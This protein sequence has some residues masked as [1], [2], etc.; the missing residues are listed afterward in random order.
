MGLFGSGMSR[1]FVIFVSSV[2]VVSIILVAVAFRYV[3]TENAGLVRAMLLSGSEELLL[4][5]TGAVMDRVRGGR[6]NHSADLAAALKNAAA[7]D[8]ALLHILVFSRTSDDDY[9]RVL[10]KVPLN[11]AFRVEAEVKSVVTLERETEHLKKGVYAPTVDPSVYESGAFTW[12]AVYQPFRLRNRNLVVGFFSSAGRTASALVEYDASIRGIKRNVAVINAA[13]AALV[14]LAVA[15]F[16]HSYS[17]FLKNLAGYFG[18]ASRGDLAVN[19][20][21]PAGDEMQELAASFNGLI[22][23]MR[24]LKEAA[25]QPPAARAPEESVV[26]GRSAEESPAAAR[27]SIAEES[28]AEGTSGEEPSAAPEAAASDPVD[29]IFKAGVRKLK[30]GELDEAI[31]IFKALQV[32]RPESFGSYFNLGVACARLRRYDEA[33]AMFGKALE[34]NPAHD[35]ARGYV[36]KVTQ[37]KERYGAGP[38]QHSGQA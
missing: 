36:E 35:L 24:S 23:E 2:F 4:E 8:P 34:I 17:L 7:G 26:D 6:Y 21:A 15:L 18:R 10:E 38:G 1:R 32:I 16:I 25:A 12:R 11:A 30:E 22:E 29:E 14:A 20:S 9:Y 37:L 13:A 3:I 19:I 33:L 27:E 31:H 5:K 28:P